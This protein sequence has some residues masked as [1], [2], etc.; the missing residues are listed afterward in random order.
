LA[1]IISVFN[2]VRREGIKVGM[3]ASKVLVWNAAMDRAIA[4]AMESDP[5]PNGE[6]GDPGVRDICDRFRHAKIEST[7]GLEAAGI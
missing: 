2:E 3:G 7:A 5:D 6:H 4:L 1:D